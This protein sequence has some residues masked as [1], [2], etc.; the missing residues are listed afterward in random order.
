[1]KMTWGINNHPFDGPLPNVLAIITVVIIAVVAGLCIGAAAPVSKYWQDVILKP[2][3]AWIERYGYNNES[4]LAYNTARIIQLG[5]AQGMEIQR[6]KERVA[7]LEA[8]LKPVDPNSEGVP[9]E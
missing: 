3:Q 1:M 8:S 6:L 5:N 2:E 7:S 9:R 4:V